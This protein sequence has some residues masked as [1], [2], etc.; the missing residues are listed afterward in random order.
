M[1]VS[2]L[3]I[4]RSLAAL[5]LL[6]AAALPAAGAQ[7]TAEW[8]RL[9]DTYVE[10]GPDGVNRVDYAALQANQADRAALDV[11]IASFED[12]DL[13]GTGDEAFAAWL[14]YNH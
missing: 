6:A 3:P 4:A 2:A 8:T 12:R 5:F 10:T 13:S 7:E 14:L 1:I 9:L 11:Y